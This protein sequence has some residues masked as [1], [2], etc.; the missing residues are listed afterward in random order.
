MLKTGLCSITFR[1]LNAEQIISLVQKAGLDAIEWG[2][3]CHAPPGDPATA[4]TIRRQ[5]GDAGITISSY[6]SYYKVLDPDGAPEPFEP[7]LETAVA[8]GTDTIRIWAG[9]HPSEG[10]EESYRNK[11]IETLRKNLDAAQKEGV[12]VA[13]E[14]HAN[15]MADSNFATAALLNALDHP[16]L[17]TYWQPVYWLSD[18]DYRMQGLEQLAPRVLNLHV[19]QWLFR[20]GLG[21]WGDS[22]DRRPLEDGAAEWQRYLRVPLPSPGEHFALMEFVRNDDPDQFLKDATVLRKWCTP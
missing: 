5:G 20:P 17:F 14:F 7:M 11:L 15:T 8:L 9:H 22:T 18:P 3:D 6:G 12:R 1:Q 2:S 10:L 19:F 21:S 13:L 4:A 16:N